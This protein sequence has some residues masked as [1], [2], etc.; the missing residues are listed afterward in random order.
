VLNKFRATSSLSSEEIASS[1]NNKTTETYKYHRCMK[2]TVGLLGT[3][4]HKKTKKPRKP[5]PTHLDS[6]C[7][8]SIKGQASSNICICITMA[9]LCRPVLLDVVSKTML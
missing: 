9:P 6:F 4:L 3:C 2:Q 7:I 1:V 8:E 5:H